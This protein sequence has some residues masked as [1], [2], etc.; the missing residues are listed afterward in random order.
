M[1]SRAI[2]TQANQS[3]HIPSAKCRIDLKAAV[4]RVLQTQQHFSKL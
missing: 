2:N 1:G 4:L 3:R